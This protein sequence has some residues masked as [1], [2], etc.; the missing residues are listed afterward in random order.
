MLVLE[1]NNYQSIVYF[2]FSIWLVPPFLL[3][4]IGLLFYPNH[5]LTAKILFGIA[6]IYLLIGGGI[7]GS[8]LV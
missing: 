5:K 4:L 1:V 8:F 3:F 2:I 6:L 7:C